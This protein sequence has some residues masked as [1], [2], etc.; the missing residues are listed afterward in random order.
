MF[1]VFIINVQIYFI[2]INIHIFLNI[3]FVY[4][5][6]LISYVRNKRTKIGL[7]MDIQR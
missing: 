6:I 5:I 2:I 1:S 7:V 4:F 3:L